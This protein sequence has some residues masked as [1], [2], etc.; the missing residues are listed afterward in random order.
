MKSGRFFTSIF[1]LAVLSIL[2]PARTF[3]FWG[4]GETEGKSGLN[5][6]Q[7]YD[8]NMVATVRGKVISVG[9]GESG[10]P[11]TI[12]IRQGPQTIHAITAPPWFW[13]DRGIAIQPQDEVVVQGA[14]A[15][16]KDGAMYLISRQVSNISTGDSVTLR[17]ATGRPIW[18]GSGSAGRGGNGMQRR[19]GGGARG[20]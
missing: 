2:L 3:A 9:T 15:Q 4:F 13:S 14:K 12:I 16:G 7:G 20:R 6:D 8:L 17:S 11:V 10:G 1:Y 5:F 19:Y 18:K